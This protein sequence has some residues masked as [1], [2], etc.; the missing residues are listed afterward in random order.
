EALGEKAH[1]VGHPQLDDLIVD[2]RVQ[3]IRLISGGDRHIGAEPQNVV[4]VYP[5][6]IR[7]LFGARIALETRSRQRIERKDLGAFFPLLSAGAVEWALA[8]SPIE[9]GDVAAVERQPSDA[10]AINIHAANPEAGQ[11][12]LVDLG[13]RGFGWVWP[14]RHPHDVTGMCQTRTPDRA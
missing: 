12:D 11:R 7:V 3:R 14:W 4:L 10:V 1:R 6:E 8:L 2:Q 13:Q 9:T 5:D